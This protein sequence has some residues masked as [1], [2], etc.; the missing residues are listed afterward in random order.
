MQI[1]NGVQ[2]HNGVNL[3]LLRM[4][5]YLPDDYLLLLLDLPHPLPTV[6]WSNINYIIEPNMIADRVEL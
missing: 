6:E 5:G 4:S 3:I 1:K 2:K